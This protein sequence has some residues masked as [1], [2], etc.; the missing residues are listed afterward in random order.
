MAP[1]KI[2]FIGAGHIAESIM[3]GVITSGYLDPGQIVISDL[4]QKRLIH[5][6]QTLGASIAWSNTDNAAQAELLFLAVKP[7]QVLAVAEEIRA[8]V[9][10]EQYVVSVAA[11]TSIAGIQKILE[12]PTVCRVMPNLAATV[13]HSTIGLY[14]APDHSEK[15]LAPVYSLLSRI[16]K[17]YR[18]ADE[19]QMAAV[20]ALSGSAPAYYVMMAEALVNYGVEQGIPR[21]LARAMI[22]GTMAGSAVWAENAKVR[23]GEL[24]RKVVTPGGTTE[25]GINYFNEKGFLEIFIEGLTRSTNRARELGDR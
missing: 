2:G 13:R 6:H 11:G 20:T 10:A 19:A 5:V 15:D 3:R 4:D 8:A 18:I 7:A 24:W 16:G 23:L 22:L 9:R 25:A 12:R 17:V 1:D 14:A 21:D